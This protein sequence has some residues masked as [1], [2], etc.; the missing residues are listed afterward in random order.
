MPSTRGD[1]VSPPASLREAL[2]AG[3]TIMD[4]LLRQ[5]HLVPLQAGLINRVQ[6]LH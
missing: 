4:F 1:A 3:V 6:N 5:N 2:R